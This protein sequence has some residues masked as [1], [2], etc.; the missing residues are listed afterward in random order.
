LTYAQADNEEYVGLSIM[1]MVMVKEK[2][3][4]LVCYYN[5]AGKDSMVK[6]KA[7]ND[8]IVLSFLSANQDS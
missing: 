6:A 8:Y 7:K 3:I 2:L 4:T 5:Y 1:N